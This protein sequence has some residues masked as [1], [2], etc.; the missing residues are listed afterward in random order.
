MIFGCVGSVIAAPDYLKKFANIK[1]GNMLARGSAYIV[2]S[3]SQTK[4]KITK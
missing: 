3:E 4:S 1:N 2:E